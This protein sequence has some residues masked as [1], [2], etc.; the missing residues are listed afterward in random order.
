MS[1]CRGAAAYKYDHELLPNASEY[2]PADPGIAEDDPELKAELERIEERLK[3][4][5][6]DGNLLYSK[7]AFD[8]ARTFLTA[9]SAKAKK[10]YGSFLPVPDIGPGPEKSIDLHWETAKYE[11]LINISSD[12]PA[13][14]YG[15][16]YGVRKIKGSLDPAT[17]DLG[18]ILW[19]MKD[20]IN[21]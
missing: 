20:Q 11:L 21:L 9:Q 14:Y 10:M 16:D 19:L 8:R 18:I 6:D 12:K 1:S 3:T 2:Q 15:D 7:E 5:D 4:V 13:V 17:W